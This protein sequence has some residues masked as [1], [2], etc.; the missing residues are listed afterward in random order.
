MSRFV[1]FNPDFTDF[2]VEIDDDELFV[3]HK[4]CGSRTLLPYTQ[5][6]F[7][8]KEAASHV[9]EVVIGGS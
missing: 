8:A 2:D 9:C 4:P 7:I 3:I 5:F 1:R 6:F